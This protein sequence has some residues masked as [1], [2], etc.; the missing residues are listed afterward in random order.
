LYRLST[1]GIKNRYK[2]RIRFYNNDGPAF[3]EIKR[4]IAETIFKQRA[5][6]T[7]RAAE[8]LLLGGGIGTADLVSRNEKS[9]IALAEFCE[10]M[11]QLN[12][13]GMAF[14]SFWREAYVLP[15][16]EGARVTFDRQIAGQNYLPGGGLTI[17]TAEAAVTPDQVV[18]EL[19]YMGRAP[20]WMKDLVGTFGLTR[21][22]FPKYVHSIDALHRAPARAG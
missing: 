6:V 9:V 4:R 2:L 7:R 5:A 18:L 17:P 13:Q 1:E 21:I 20:G 15:H 11:A 16:A 19:K 3:L 22:S 14:V 10:R 12:A 8:D